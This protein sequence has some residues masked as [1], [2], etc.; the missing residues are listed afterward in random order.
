MKKIKVFNR[1]TNEEI[2]DKPHRFVAVDRIG[3]VIVVNLI[4]GEH[5]LYF[6]E[7]EQDEY[8]RVEV[9]E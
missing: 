3:N 8:Y 4:F 7:G 6:I 2:V 5:A 9:I 1:T